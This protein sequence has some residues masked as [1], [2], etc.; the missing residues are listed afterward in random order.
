MSGV[1]KKMTE[2]KIKGEKGK[3]KKKK[4]TNLSNQKI[5]RLYTPADIKKNNYKKACKFNVNIYI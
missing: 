3:E 4:F 1:N 5:E 2:K